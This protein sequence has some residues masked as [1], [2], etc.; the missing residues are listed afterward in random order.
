MIKRAAESTCLALAAGYPIVA[1]TGPRQSGKT[2][3]VKAA[4]PGKPYVSFEDP[5]QLESASG[6]P[7]G[8]LSRFPSGAIIDE[9]QRFPKIFSYLQG[10]VDDRK[11]MGLFI[12][13]G[14]QQFGLLSGISQS[15]AGRAA[16]VQ[17]LPFSLGEAGGGGIELGP[18]SKVLISGLYPPIHDRHL[19]P[20]VWYGNYVMTY[21]ERDVRNL[22]AVRDLS[23]F[24]TF[25]R[26]CAARCGRLLNLSSLA[27][28]CGIT[29]NT[30]R[31][32]ISVL[33]ASYIVHLLRPHSENFGK[34]MVKAPKLY[35]YDPGLAAWLLNIQGPDHMA[36]H[37]MR[38][39][40]FEA[41]IVSEFL[42]ARY[43]RGLESNLYFW[44][45]N[46]GEE[47]D[48][49]I[50]E[51]TV[52]RPVEI[53]SGETVS[54]DYFRGLKRRQAWVAQRRQRAGRSG[55]AAVAAEGEAGVPAGDA[56]DAGAVNPSDGTVIY[57]GGESFRQGPFSVVSWRNLV[58]EGSG[59]NI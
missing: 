45:D 55:S 34:R 32:W 43:N 35:F 47:I 25:L 19:D 41:L 37:P 40:L 2:T 20:A 11:K 44:R 36:V 24:R 56:I 7:H 46:I 29:H 58:L 30:A 39:E 57:G 5:D 31:S 18:L 23:Q 14:S 6:D 27:S 8:F 53:K 10:F 50:D 9:A 1:V 33:E 59:L 4:F 16:L 52:V 3:L 42:K 26:M 15:L 48:L 12:L 21:L 13:T 49:L 17:L 22:L 38:G 54:E 51:G 28:D